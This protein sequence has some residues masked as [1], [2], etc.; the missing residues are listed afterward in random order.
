MLLTVSIRTDVRNAVFKS[1]R[2]LLT[3]IGR[4]RHNVVFGNPSTQRNIL[5]L[6]KA[7]AA[8]LVRAFSRCFR[9]RKMAEPDLN[10]ISRGKNFFTTLHVAS[11]II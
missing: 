8:S 3:A 6:R 7:R 5:T 9:L 2:M 1:T 10:S 11:S 4:N